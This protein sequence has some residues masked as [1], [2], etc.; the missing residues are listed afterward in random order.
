VPQ[1][2]LVCRLV[3]TL[4]C[5]WPSKGL[6][7]MAQGGCAAERPGIEFGGYLVVVMRAHRVCQTRALWMWVPLT[8]T[9]CS[10]CTAVERKSQERPT[11][12]LLQSVGD[13]V[14][15]S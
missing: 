6:T 1:M 8:R 4:L 12:S 10:T 11:S 3:T 7:G 5:G 9:I 14:L 2:T 15:A 13:L